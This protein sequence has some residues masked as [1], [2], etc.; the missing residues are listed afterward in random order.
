M[1]KLS[2]FALLAVLAIASSTTVRQSP[3]EVFMTQS[4]AKL[5][6]LLCD[7]CQD[8]VKDAENAGTDYSD[9]WLDGK[10]GEV[11][12]RLGFLSGVC[13]DALKH[14]V[15]DLDDMI[16]AKVEPEKCCKKVDLC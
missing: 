16:K 12:K 15:G 14:L 2:V 10:I 13:E 5:G 4:L 11:C 6:G 7:L 8:L 9:H 3:K 1:N